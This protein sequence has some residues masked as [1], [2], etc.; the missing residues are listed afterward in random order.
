MTTTL[1]PGD[2]NQATPGP[3]DRRPDPARAGGRWVFLSRSS[4]PTDPTA[5][6]LEKRGRWWLAVSY[7]LCPCHL[8]VTLS[9]AGLAFGGTALGSTIAGHATWVGIALTS[10]YAVVL[11]RGFRQLRRS[12]RALAAGESL[13]CSTSG[14]V[15]VPASGESG[16]SE[17]EPS[18]AL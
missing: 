15:I 12:K 2:G 17:P 10:A 13:Q 18:T 7:V 1:R 14:C 11:W 8:P 6:R 9:L 3:T 5:R 16:T 4:L